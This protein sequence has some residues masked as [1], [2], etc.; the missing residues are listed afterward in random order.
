MASRPALGI[1]LLEGKMAD[2]PGCMA[3]AATFHYPVIYE[4]VRGSRPPAS[5]ADV[6]AM[7]PLYIDAAQELE[8]RGA[9][10]ITDNCN[11]LMVLMQDRLAAAVRVPVITSALLA[12]PEIHRLLP[13]RRIGILAFHASAVS[14]EVYAACGWSPAEIPVAVGEVGGS[15]AWQ[16]F[17]RTKE[18]PDELR[19]R[20]E[21]DL[22]AAGRD[23]L[24][25]HPDIGVFVSECTLLPPCCQALRDALGLPVYD[26][27]TLLDLAV[28]GSWRP[29]APSCFV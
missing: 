22:I 26:I 5:P 25:A 8:R 28:A 24:A 7:V 6:E 27:L 29:A 9:R 3:C 15:A 10:V 11:G 21:A 12:V 18:I 20:L 4:V 19:P 14:N 17:L 1:L 23:L 16:Q 13:E 2:V